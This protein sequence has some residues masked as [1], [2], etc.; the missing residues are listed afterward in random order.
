MKIGKVLLTLLTLS[1]LFA[2]C[3]NSQSNNGINLQQFF[4]ILDNYE[5]EKVLVYEHDS[6]G[7]KTDN[8][9]I[10][11]K[12]D[13]RKLL[14]KRLSKDFQV[15]QTYTDVYKEDGVYLESSSFTEGNPELEPVI[16]KVTSGKIFPFD[17]VNKEFA[18]FST[19]QSIVQPNI[20]GDMKDNW[21]LT[22]VE[23][24]KIGDE[25]KKVM[26][27]DGDSERIF[28]DIS[29]GQKSRLTMDIEYRYTEG[30]GLTYIK[31]S[32]IYGIYIDKYLRTISIEDFN[33]L[34]K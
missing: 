28:T 22:K 16:V 19:F 7:M 11:K 10:L 3:S 26:F 6:A 4:Y 27:V 20:K 30:I 31:S 23:E 18:S 14:V 24:R 32:S 12:I 2:R 33:K 15:I 25:V 8:Y 5:Q 21:K 9:F 1:L 13:E 34:K 17:N 29:T